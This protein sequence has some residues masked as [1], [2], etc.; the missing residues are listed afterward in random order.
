MNKVTY[1]L[2]GIA[3]RLLK[4]DPSYSVYYNNSKQRYE[5]HSNMGLAFIVPYDCLD[6]RT[7]DYAR[8][9]LRQ[10]ADIIEQEIETHNAGVVNAAKI[11]ADKAA[12]ELQQRLEFANRTGR[13]VTFTKDYIKEF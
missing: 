10:N 7:I 6:S 2:F 4:I 8:K 1:D 9:T 3:T 12:V 13:T 5:V 11:N